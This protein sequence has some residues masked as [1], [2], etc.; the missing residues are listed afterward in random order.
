MSQNRFWNLLA[1]KLSGEAMPDELGELEILIKKNPEWVY[2]AEHIENLW[3]L[4][5]RDL[6]GTDAEVAFQMHVNRHAIVGL[7]MVQL[8]T[9]LPVNEFMTPPRNRKTRTLYFSLVGLM[10]VLLSV[11]LWNLY[12]GR[13]ATTLPD[14]GFSEV[15]TRPGSKSRVVLPDSSI[16]WLN[17]GSKLTYND[18]FGVTNR[19]A[20]L[21][22]EAFFDVRKNKIPF[23]I[24]ANTVNIKVLGTAFNV[25]S[26]PGDRLTETS[27]IRG[28]IEITLN[29]RPGEK[30]LLKPNE[31]LIVNHQEEEQKKV[32]GKG[33]REPIFILKELTYSND[34]NIETSWLENK[35]IFQ[36][37]SFAEVARK[38]ERWYDVTIE[39]RNEKLEN[40]RLSGTFTNEN[41]H[42][43]LLLL[44]MTTPFHFTIKSNSV[45]ITQ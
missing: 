30:I 44:Q 33:S 6:D 21:T 38:M 11:Y 42:E 24:T 4:K 2:A 27:L 41:V 9:P 16:V 26:Y 40:E 18:Q 23:I 17:A 32:S 22:G 35:L 14:K 45:I 39:F 29:K 43:A 28:S 31:K 34:E 8:Q 19:N 3:K 10:V 37:E 7:D 5:A 15:S 25:K 20:T 1:K 36:D 13:R 12:S